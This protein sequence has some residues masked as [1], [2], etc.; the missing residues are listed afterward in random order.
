MGGSTKTFFPASG[1]YFDGDVRSWCTD[2]RAITVVGYSSDGQF[3]Y[4]GLSKGGKTVLQL[5]QFLKDR[6]AHEVL[7]LDSGGSSQMYHNGT[8]ISGTGSDYYR[9]IANAFAVTIDNAPPPP[10]S[11]QWRVEYFSDKNLGGRCYEGYENSI[12]ILKNFGGGSPASGCPNDN[13]SAR[14]TSNVNFGGGEYRFHCQHDDGCR[15]YIDGQLR[16]DAWWDSSFTGHDWAGSLSG[17]RQVRIEMYDSGGD[18][19]IEAWWQGNGFLPRDE[20]RDPNQWYGEYFANRDLLGTPLLKRNEGT[21]TLDWRWGS[22]GVGYGI[23]NDNFSARWTRTVNFPAGQYRFYVRH[24]DGA[25]LYIDDALKLDVWN[26]CCGVRTVDV[27]LTS[28]NHTLRLEWYDSG[29]DAYA[30]VWWDTLTLCYDLATTVSPANTGTLRVCEN[31][32]LQQDVPGE[33][34]VYFSCEE[35]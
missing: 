3:L 33:S 13:F 7:R 11:G 14:F 27:W 25:R 32:L 22:G 17:T 9:A 4:M 30:G 18:A 21:G 24:D 20:N 26:N 1:E 6:G 12:F 31:I 29:G 8:Y 35:E 19:R 16:L 10:P 23:P 5:A 2:T 15:I 34:V 28:G